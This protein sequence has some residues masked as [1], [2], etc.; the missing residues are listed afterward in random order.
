MNLSHFVSGL[1]AAL[2]I[3]AVGGQ[4]VCNNAELLCQRTYDNLTHLGA[5]DAAFVRDLGNGFTPAG[6]QFYNASALLSYGVRLLSAQ[7]HNA[8]DGIHL[9]HTDC[10]LYD[11]GLMVDW[12]TDIREWI[13][14]N[15]RDVV[16]VLIVNSDNF[17]AATLGGIFT[18]AGLTK[19]AYVPSSNVGPVTWPTLGNMVSTNKRFVAWIASLDPVKNTAAPFLLDE[20]SFIFENQYD[21]TDASKFSCEANRPSSV[22]GD[23]ASALKKGLLPLTN[24]FLDDNLFGTGIEVPSV[25][26]VENTNRDTGDTGNFG[27]AVNDC[28]KTYDRAPV[29]TLVDFANVGPAIATVDRLNQVSGQIAGR[30]QLPADVAGSMA[31][32]L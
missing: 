7:A 9:C 16:S 10:A 4:Q 5:H 15:P 24:H 20:F 2:C 25:E 3:V 18:T 19:Y 27:D 22:N 17:D 31:D 28:V 21:V 29:F 14:A 12:L 26:H 1:V 32:S 8:D 23:T 11:G 30:V 13:D 6:N